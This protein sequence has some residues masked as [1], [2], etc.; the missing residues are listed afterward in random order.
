MKNGS[1]LE[2]NLEIVD[3][4]TQ[5]LVS[6]EG[7]GDFDT[8][9]TVGVSTEAIS[10][11]I[12]DDREFFRIWLKE[13][14]RSKFPNIGEIREASDTRGAVAR[15]KSQKP[16]LIFLDIDFKQDRS[17]NGIQ[18]AAE[19]WKSEPQMPIMIVSSYTDQIYLKSLHEVAPETASYGYLLKDTETRRHKEKLGAV[20]NCGWLLVPLLDAG[21]SLGLDGP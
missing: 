8:R 3:C 13:E 4:S 15:A 16:G 5:A 19:T 21:G 11:L 7:E 10:I 18:V 17:M 20:R 6:D 2:N 1:C 14:F 9:R 12:A